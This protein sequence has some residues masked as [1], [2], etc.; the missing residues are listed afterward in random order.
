V[1][2]PNIIHA[3]RVVEDIAVRYQENPTVIGIEPGTSL[4]AMGV[5]S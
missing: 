3:L 5:L 2:L 4:I 1:N